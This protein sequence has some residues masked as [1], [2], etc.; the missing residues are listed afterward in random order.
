MSGFEMTRMILASCQPDSVQDFSIVPQSQIVVPVPLSQRKPDQHRMLPWGHC[1]D[2]ALECSL[3]CLGP[4][5]PLPRRCGARGGQFVQANCTSGA[6]VMGTPDGAAG[7]GGVWHKALV[8]G[9]VSL[10]RRLLASRP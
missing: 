9:S 6:P 3:G 1:S 10:W 5:V 4:L 8:V 7:S 2:T